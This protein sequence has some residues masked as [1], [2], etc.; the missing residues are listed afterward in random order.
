MSDRYVRPGE[1]P[2]GNGQSANRVADRQLEASSP[3]Q[4]EQEV[5]STGLCGLWKRPQRMHQIDP[6]H[7]LA[8]IDPNTHQVVSNDFV[9]SEH[10]TRTK[11]RD[12][13]HAL[14]KKT[15][16]CDEIREHLQA[17]VGEL[18]DLKSSKQNF[19]VDDA[20]MTAKWKG[21]QYSIKNLS[22]AY[23]Y[24]LIPL[25]QLTRDQVKLLESV[26]PLCQQILST[27]GQVHLL[28]QSLIW[29]LIALDILQRP[30]TVWRENLSTAVRTVLEV[31]WNSMEDRHAWRAQTGQIIQGAE[32]VYD[33][34]K[35]YLKRGL[36]NIIS[37]FIPREQ[38]SNDTRE[39]I[40]RRSTRE[41]IDKAIELAVIFNQSR[42]EY[43]VE[44]VAHGERFESVLMEYSEECEAPRVDLMVSP[45]LIKCGNSQG[46]HY[47]RWLV[48]AKSHV[49][50]FNQT[51]QEG[52]SE[53][54]SLIYL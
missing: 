3:V 43:S 9:A 13:K 29:T 30:T 36:R 54:E 12:I 41:I 28:F 16:E 51:P 7:T 32:G 24:N 38:L 11:L 6:N 52:K 26:S 14:D 33:G 18:N 37:Q 8:P 2:A 15:E 4:A 27:E 23:L 5:A 35:A 34:Q 1:R 21:L 50:S 40:F 10:Q 19:V 17:V 39:L 46:E 47:D 44:M 31:K 49:H 45:A 48:L 20:E 53:D 25:N 22:R 42:C